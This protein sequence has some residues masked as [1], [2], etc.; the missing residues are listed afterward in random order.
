MSLSKADVQKIAV[1]ARLALTD[2]E[3]D[4]YQNELNKIL[5]WV[6]QLQAIPTDGVEEMAS[7]SA[8]PLPWREDKVTDGQY[9]DAVLAN[10]P[11][12]DY[13]CFVVPKVVE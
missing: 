7:V 11:K 9:Q 6:D 13:G 4:H 5:S 12:A 1:L 3:V 8:V 2:E 10:A